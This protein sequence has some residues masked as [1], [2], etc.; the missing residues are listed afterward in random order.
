[1]ETTK[2][3]TSTKHSTSQKWS[4]WRFL[5]HLWLAF[6]SCETFENNFGF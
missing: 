3:N 2:I 4:T 6:T 5:K 1:M